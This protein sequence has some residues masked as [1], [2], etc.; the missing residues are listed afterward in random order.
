[1]KQWWLAALIRAAKTFAETAAAGIAV[2]AAFSDIDW[3]FLLSVAGV[4]FVASLLASV[5][6]IPE[7]EG[8]KSAWKLGGGGGDED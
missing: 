6:G 3:A 5:K 1:M 7:V 4:A 8:G 2:G